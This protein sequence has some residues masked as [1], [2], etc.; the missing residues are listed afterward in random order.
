[1]STTILEQFPDLSMETSRLLADMR[2]PAARAAYAPAPSA[3]LI[4]EA[5]LEASRRAGRP[6]LEAGAADSTAVAGVTAAVDGVS[7]PKH[8]TVA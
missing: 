2:N 5:R 4:M 8:P 3:A 6:A 7:R 1:M